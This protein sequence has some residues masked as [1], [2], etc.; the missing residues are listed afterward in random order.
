MATTVAL[1]FRI[2]GP[3]S[4]DLELKVGNEIF[5]ASGISY[6][7]DAVGDLLRSAIM[8]AT[9]SD[10]A[11]VS[12]DREP[13]E[14]RIQLISMLDTDT[15]L[16]PVQIRIF[17]FDD[18]YAKR[19]DTEGNQVFLADCGALD[20]ASAVLIMVKGIRDHFEK[21]GLELQH[22]P[23]AALQVLEGALAVER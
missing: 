22:F 14:W 5:V 9:G 15:G 23:S 17:E 11:T 2:I 20:F 6:T 10:R 7:S 8:I 19:P 21:F 12:L 3:G 1:D 13:A 16:G 4:A 18:F